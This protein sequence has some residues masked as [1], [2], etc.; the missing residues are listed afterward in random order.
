MKITGLTAT[1]V[2]VPL[3]PAPSVSKMRMGPRVMLGV[4]VEVFTDEG[5]TGIGETPAVLGAD[6]SAKIVRS[7]EKVLVG[8]ELDAINPLM[9]M[10]YVQYNLAHLHIHA[11]SW[12]LSG[13][14][15]ALWDLAGQRAGMPLY[16]LWGGAYRKK[17]EFYG[18]VERQEL[19]GM[20]A[21]AAQ[22]AKLGFKTIY[23]K[24][25]LDPD[26]DVAAVAA[27][28]RGAPG[29]DVKIRVDANQAWSTGVAI[30][31]INR[32][33]EYGMEFVDQPVIMYNIEALRDVKRSVS[34]PIAG[35]ESCWTMYELLNVL[36]ANAVDYIHVDARFDAGYTG[37]RISAG[38]AEAAGVQCVQHS[39]FEL[40]VAFAMNLH[41]IASC[42]NFTLANQLV[43]YNILQD[44]VLCGGPLKMEGPHV[45]VPEGPG[46]GVRL[47]Q[48]RMAKYHELYIK[49]VLE[50]G[51]ERETEN[52]YYAAMHMRP[53]FKNMPNGL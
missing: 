6:I 43:E 28:R 5:L 47:D 29:G 40:G 38:M 11:A 18:D 12:A 37:A 36:K 34:V 27:M 32:M 25:G 31:T 50:K 15:M 51:F 9:K 1:P 4:I 26:D 45:E 48:A 22:L 23:T 24:V 10:L 39:F 2:A 42:P 16:Q 19:S 17:V 3:H 30:S 41:L 14:E 21:R 44:D 20:T 8:K 46:V 33:A 13:I 52:H 53:Y 49:E 35:H 7:A